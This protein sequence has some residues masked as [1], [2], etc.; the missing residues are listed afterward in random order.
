MKLFVRDIGSRTIGNG[1]EKIHRVLITSCRAD[2][3][4]GD[5]ITCNQHQEGLDRLMFS[6]APGENLNEAYLPLVDPMKLD[7]KTREELVASGHYQMKLSG[8]SYDH[9]SVIIPLIDENTGEKQ[10]GIMLIFD[11]ETV[12]T[13]FAQ[14]EWLREDVKEKSGSNKI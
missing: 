5:D 14:R 6:Y 9:P 3:F 13:I 10:P 2:D 11:P 7:A 8:R 1:N 12:E 4:D